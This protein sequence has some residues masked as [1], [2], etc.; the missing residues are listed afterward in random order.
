MSTSLL[1]YNGTVVVKM[2]D[3]TIETWCSDVTPAKNWPNDEITCDIM[4]G[5]ISEDISIFHP[6]YLTIPNDGINE[7][8]DW[9]LIEVTANNANDMA[10]ESVPTVLNQHPELVIQIKLKRNNTFYRNV[11]YA[12]TYVIEMLFLLTFFLDG[13]QRS[14]INLLALLLSF[15][16]LIFIAKF[17]PITYIPDIVISYEMLLISCT[18]AFFLHIILQWL[19]KY[20]P[21]RV[22]SD[23]ILIIINNPILRFILAIRHIDVSM[24]GSWKLTNTIFTVE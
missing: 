17:S 22:P 2:M 21:Q 13:Q 20:P 8:S 23:C 4:F 7:F 5:T 16:G 24:L 6:G 18:S 3:V 1:H 19:T 9:E 12:P 14:S 10:I 15:M 11:F